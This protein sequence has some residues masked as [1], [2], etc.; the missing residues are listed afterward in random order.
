MIEPK[1]PDNE[2]L[3]QQALDS[4]RI[5]DTKSE[6]RFERITRLATK[7]VGV[8]ISAISLIDRD[9]QWFKSIQGLDATE[10]PRNISFCGHAIHG[11][12]TFI[13]ENALKDVRFSDNPL[14]SENPNI[15]FYAGH[16]IKSPDG[17]RIGTLCVIDDHP[18][19]ISMDELESLVDLAAMVEMELGRLKAIEDSKMKS[20]F[21][22]TMSHEIRTPMN[23]VIGMTSLLLN[24]NLDED[25]K[26]FATVIRSSGDA[27]LALINDILDFSKIEAN[28]IELEP[29][30]FDLLSCIEEP[31][32]IL[33]GK[34]REKGLELCYDIASGLPESF[35]GDET[36]I[37]QIL[38]NL[39]S[40]A[41]KFT[42]KGKIS[43][44]VSAEPGESN[45][46]Q[47][48]IDVTDTGIGMS[49][50]GMS[51]IFKSFVQAD[52]STTRKFGGT[53][54]GLA[55]S[56]KLAELMGGDIAVSSREGE[57]TTFSFT[58]P[59]AEIV[60]ETAS[61]MENSEGPSNAKKI[62]SSSEKHVI[63]K[64]WAEQYPLRILVVEDNTV[65]QK[66]ISHILKKMGYL[67]DLAGNG[68]EAI[69]GLSRQDY[70]VILMDMEMPVMNGLDATIEIRKNFPASKQPK[71]VAL[72]ANVFSEQRK[73][74]M[75]AG[76]D[77]YMS[78]PIKVSVL[79]DILK[80]MH[81]QS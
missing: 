70:D 50:K 20:S 46:W 17:Y 52:Q 34:A 28:H 63:D 10:T 69:E 1:F 79:A 7:M 8:P 11:D 53:G 80:Q 74:C 36:R 12:E 59:L 40:N 62:S 55:I 61:L 72:T 2:L 16:P 6:E 78:K 60:R 18:K 64:K 25:Q 71:I 67:C 49:P 54:L 31:I 43:L 77:E 5:L 33:S 15:R 48:K 42:E 38:M 73:S 14:V 47:L 22:A 75:E 44:S 68:K 30:N 19:K 45:I 39:L 76:M 35:L 37:R 13:V 51:R 9:R 26:E 56:K 66:V 32:D 58:V 81:D 21:L 24:T 4:L 41:V 65:N 57:G 23:A 27:L 3:R 29:V